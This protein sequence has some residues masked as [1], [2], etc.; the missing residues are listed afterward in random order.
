MGCPLKK[1]ARIPG[2]LEEPQHNPRVGD[3]GRTLESPVEPNRPAAGRAPAAWAR[4]GASVPSADRSIR[5]TPS[6]SSVESRADPASIPRRP[7]PPRGR[8]SNRRGERI[9]ARITAFFRRPGFG[10]AIADGTHYS[11]V[12]RVAI[13][14]LEGRGA[15]LS[16]LSL[17]RNDPWSQAICGRPVRR[18][19]AAAMPACVPFDSVRLPP[20]AVESAPLSSLAVIAMPN[21][22]VGKPA[23]TDRHSPTSD[24]LRRPSPT[25]NGQAHPW[26]RPQ[27]LRGIQILGTGSYVPELVVS[28]HDL[29]THPRL[30]PGLDRE[31]DGHPRATIRAAAPG[32]ERPV[33][34]GGDPLPARG[35][36]RAGRGGP[37][38]ARH[39][40]ARHGVSFDGQPGAGSAQAGLPGVRRP[41]GLRR[42]RIRPGDR[43]AV[44]RHREQPACAW[45]S[46]ATAT[47][48]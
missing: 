32:D 20:P 26:P 11:Q 40:H 17:R 15:G 7:G 28:N 12:I 30:R 44:R 10:L 47:A 5:R 34:S 33:Q 4:S 46:A 16:S 41:G 6:P 22:R 24:E 39:V 48:A 18:L 21:D 2:A 9:G 3:P 31:S 45:S 1:M 35:R 36:P 13:G 29:Q 38:G 43:G 8:A 27:S 37:A 23:H 14:R 19:T 25:S 42:V